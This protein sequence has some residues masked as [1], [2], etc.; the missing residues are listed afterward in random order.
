MK[1][2]NAE[3]LWHRKNFG[4]SECGPKFESG[5]VFGLEQARRLARRMIKDEESRHAEKD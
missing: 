4:T 5:F 3:I 1:L 2:L